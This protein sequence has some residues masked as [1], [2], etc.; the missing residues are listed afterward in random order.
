MPFRHDVL[1]AIDTIVEALDEQPGAERAVLTLTRQDRHKWTADLAIDTTQ[2]EA[3]GVNI[4]IGRA[5]P[6]TIVTTHSS[7]TVTPS[8]TGDPTS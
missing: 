3:E 7:A 2:A 8:P 5:Q 1:A 6:E 4:R